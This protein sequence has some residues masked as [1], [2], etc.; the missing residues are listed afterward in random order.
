MVF[1]RGADHRGPADIDVLDTGFEIGAF[2]D[3]RLKGI[4]VDD[5]KIDLGDAVRLH[6]ARVIGFVADREQP[7]MHFRMQRLDPS[8]HHFRKAGQFRNVLDLQPGF[9]DRLRGAAGR[10]EFDA[11]ERQCAGEFDQP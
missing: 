9:R 10:N 1:G 7:A 8:V 4:E 11:M 6:R 3:G 5:Q 2:V